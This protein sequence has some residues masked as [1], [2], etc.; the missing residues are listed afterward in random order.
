MKQFDVISRYRQGESY[1]HIA[2][3]LGIDRKAV[4]ALCDR[5]KEGMDALVSS[6]SVQ[7]VEDATEQLVLTRSYDSSK[8]RTRTYTPA[9]EALCFTIEKYIVLQRKVDNVATQ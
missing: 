5:Y 3:E 6:K 8:R 1:R 9:V 7:E 4:K 2:R